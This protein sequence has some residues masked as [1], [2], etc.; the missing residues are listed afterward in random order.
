MHVERDLDGGFHRRDHRRAEGNV[1]HEMPVHHVEVQP[2][3]PGRLDAS[4]LLAELRKVS[5]EQGR[6]DDGRHGRKDEG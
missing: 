3:R 2:I 5:G 6:S 4:R 1:V